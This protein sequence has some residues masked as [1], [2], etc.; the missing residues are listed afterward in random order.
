MMM[1]VLKFKKGDILPEIGL[2]TWLSKPNE[3]YNAVI[4]A[5]K[6]GYRHFDCAYIY[7][8]EKE[9]GQALQFAFA[10]G[11]VKRE[12]LFIT[13][14]LWNSDHSPE[15]VLPAIKKSLKDLQLEYLDLYLI[16][17]P[18]AFKP[19]HEQ[20]FSKDDLA[21]QEESPVEKTWEA[22]VQLREM[23]LT[24]HI[25]VSN[26]NIPKINKL[27]INTGV[28]PEVNQVEMH[29]YF[30][31]KKLLK[32]CQANNILVTAYS[33]LGSRHLVK[34]DAGIQHDPLVKELALKYNCTETQIMLA[35]G[36]HRGTSVIPKSVTPE[37]IADNFKAKFIKLDEHDMKKLEELNKNQRNSKALYAVKPGGYYTYENIWEL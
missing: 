14:K 19:G 3:V 31:Q 36:I 22:M 20:A 16:H 17:W 7:G 34:T 8:N 13:S 27:I 29:L 30:Q 32:F 18:I 21:S 12:E 1:N 4:E 26:F 35:W 11:L 9:I 25:G 33:P 28:Y 10:N 23:G 15:R 24:R 5:I 37:R 6:C 2:G